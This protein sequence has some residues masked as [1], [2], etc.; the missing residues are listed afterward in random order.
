MEKETFSLITG[1]HFALISRES[2]QMS[3]KW[4]GKF[5]L[6]AFSLFLLQV[7]LDSI[8]PSTLIGAVI[9]VRILLII[10]IF[11]LYLGFILPT[12]TKKL[13]SIEE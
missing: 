12:W 5:L 2:S 6:I 7:V 3:I 8:I 11:L 4:K 1:I 13:L 9:A 10:S